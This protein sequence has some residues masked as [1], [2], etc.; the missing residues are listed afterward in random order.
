MFTALTS[1][2]RA[3]LL[4][5]VKMWT[6]MMRIPGRAVGFGSASLKNR[7]ATEPVQIKHIKPLAALIS[8]EIHC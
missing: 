3:D 2:V 6:S 1:L 4:R 7:A 5:P 8:V